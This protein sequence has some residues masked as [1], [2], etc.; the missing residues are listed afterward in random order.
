MD[1]RLPLRRPWVAHLRSPI[2]RPSSRTWPMIGWPSWWLDQSRRPIPTLVQWNSPGRPTV[3]CSHSPL[4]VR[5]S[6]PGGPVRGEHDRF[7]C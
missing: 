7:P 2:P 3:G 4:A 5:R 6:M 1:P